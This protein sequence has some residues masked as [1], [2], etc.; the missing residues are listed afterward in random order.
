M[1]KTIIFDFGGIIINLH[2]ERTIAGFQE[3]FEQSEDAAQAFSQSD[4]WLDILAPYERG[5][6]DFTAFHSDLN[7]HFGASLPAETLLTAWNAMLGDIPQAHY[8]KLTALK[9][10]GY[11]L[12][13]FSN[14]CPEHIDTI[15]HTHPEFPEYFDKIYLSYEMGH[16]KP[17]RESFEH[18]LERE[19]LIPTETL[20]FDD[21]LPNIE[22]AQSLGIQAHHLTRNE[23]IATTR[24][25]DLLKYT[26]NS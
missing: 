3:H 2:P 8:D 17:D 23:G 20:F 19:S 6:S 26:S 13:L 4:T 12:I 14:T 9:E 16:R 10:D 18:I 15:K 22:T 1:P 7:A 24:F 11:T 5:Y 21:T 25:D